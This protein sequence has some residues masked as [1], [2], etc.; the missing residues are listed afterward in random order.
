MHTTYEKAIEKINRLGTNDSE[1][2]V[3]KLFLNLGFEFIDCDAT[4]ERNKQEVGE[5]DGIFKLKDEYLFL[6]E[7]DS[8]KDPDS[9]KIGEFYS[10]WESKDNI[11]LIINKYGK[12]HSIPKEIKILRIYVNY[13]LPRPRDNLLKESLKHHDKEGNKIIYSEDIIYFQDSFTIIGGWAKN[14]LLNYLGL[15]SQ[16][17]S[18]KKSAIRI[19]MG[20]KKAFLLSANAKELLESCYIYR[21]NE[22]SLTGYQRLLKAN[23]INKIKKAIENRDILAFPNS[24]ILSSNYKLE[25]GYEIK[26]GHIQ[27]DFPTNYL[28]FKVVDGQ[29]R[30]MGFAKLNE[31]DQKDHNLPVIVFEELGKENE[32][33]TFITIN[34]EQKSIDP[35]LLLMLKAD[36]EWKENQRF[37]SDKQATVIIK[38]LNDDKNFFLCNKIF[39][40]YN[41]PKKGKITLTTLVSAILKNNLICGKYHLLQDKIS[42][43][44]K[45]NGEI[46]NIFNALKD[47][48]GVF[49][50]LSRPSKAEGFFLSNRGLRVIFRLIQF[51]VRNNI[52]NN[53]KLTYEKFF[54]DISSALTKKDIEDLMKNYGEGGANNATEAILKKVKKKHLLE[55]KRLKIDLREI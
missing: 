30:L 14:D 39:L 13:N 11:D 50:D 35:N 3:N 54:S 32:L 23:R 25:Q 1:K 42:D 29:H 2:E 7:T 4:F 49:S 38:R 28:S 40:G 31:Q 16:S 45:P 48:L 24:I 37:Y 51:M 36:F 21:K 44:E 26:S 22:G 43:M 34:T 41:N 53:F 46:K 10:K 15:D 8:K 52:K 47:K 17:T 18:V 12:S 33:K 5:I 6:V 20:G 55:Y 27:I 9:K 19:Y